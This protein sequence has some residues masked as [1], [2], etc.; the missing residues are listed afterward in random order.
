MKEI[1][2]NAVEN[3]SAFLAVSEEAPSSANHLNTHEGDKDT[4]FDN[5]LLGASIAES[6]LES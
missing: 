1:V 5:K 6:S 3:A 2:E 4:G